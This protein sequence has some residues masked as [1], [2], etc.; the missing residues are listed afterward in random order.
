MSKKQMN[1]VLTETQYE[2]LI[3]ALVEYDVVLSELY[4]DESVY[5]QRVQ[6]FVRMCR[7]LTKDRWEPDLCVAILQRPDFRG[8]VKAY[9]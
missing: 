6:A 8:R 2:M 3:T 1:M 7:I 5:V 9:R 4:D